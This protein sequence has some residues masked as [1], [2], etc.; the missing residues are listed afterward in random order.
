MA[1]S[2]ALTLSD[3]RE[4]T[5]TIVCEPC[6]RRGVYSVRRLIN[7]H[8]DAMLP[9][10]VTLLSRDCP[11]RASFSIYDQCRARIEWPN[12]PPDPREGR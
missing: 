6:N 4:A 12:G 1:R 7:K 2:G 5:L 10:L 9:H 8:A 11:K 3:I